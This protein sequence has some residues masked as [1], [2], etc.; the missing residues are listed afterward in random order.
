M[1]WSVGIKV[2]GDR[3]MTHQEIL[4]LADAV[5]PKQG[6]ATGIGTQGYGAQIVV[7]AANR[8]RAIAKAKQEFAEAVAKAGLPSYP[9]VRADAVSEE[10]D[11]AP[12]Y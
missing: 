11:A 7:V 6:I 12:Y 3:V 1:R 4:D 5:A 8:Q 10:E 9:I 2:E